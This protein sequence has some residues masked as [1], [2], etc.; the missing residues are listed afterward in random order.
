MISHRS[1]FVGNPELQF[2][3]VAQWTGGSCCFLQNF[4]GLM[5]TWCSATPKS[6][7]RHERNPCGSRL[8][9]A[10]GLANGASP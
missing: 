7:D 3:S 5:F 1:R 2:R 4:M 8:Q 9:P 10:F 6:G